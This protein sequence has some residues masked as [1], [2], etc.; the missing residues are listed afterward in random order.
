[1]SELVNVRKTAATFRRQL[2]ATASAIA[3]IGSTFG[4]SEAKASDDDSDRPSV[5]IELGGQLNRMDDGQ[6]NFAPGFPNSPARP[7]MFSPSQTFEHLPLYSVDET[8]KISF[9]PTGTDWVLSASVRYGRSD[10]DRHVRQQTNPKPFVG[11]VNGYTFT[12]YPIAAKFAST[13]VQ[14]SERHLIADFQAGKDVG[15]EMFGSKNGSSVLNFGVRFAQFSNQSN[16]ALKSDPD[17]KFSYK[18][19]AGFKIPQQAYHSNLASIEAARSFHGIGPSL[20]WNA[21]APIRSSARFV[22]TS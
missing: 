1:M 16:I 17:W 12:K 5:W 22:W 11:T 4:V 6:E 2:L 7:S 18:Y 9:E 3:L 14:N 15:L 13:V 19:Q 8:G 10:S 21:S 20:S